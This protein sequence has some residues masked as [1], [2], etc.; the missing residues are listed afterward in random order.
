MTSSDIAKNL[1]LWLGTALPAKP[2]P[3]DT[4]PG[5]I[6]FV[7]TFDSIIRSDSNETNMEAVGVGL[8]ALALFVQ[9]L[10]SYKLFSTARYLSSDLMLLKTKFQIEETRLSQWGL[11]WGFRASPLECRLAAAIEDTGHGVASIV[12]VTLLQ[13][14]TLLKE[15]EVVSTRHD[16]TNNHGQ[17]YRGLSWALR[18]KEKLESIVDNL[19]D[20]NNA[21]YEL[22]PKRDEA[23]LVEAVACAL[24][25]HSSGSELDNLITAVSRLRYA[26]ADKVA[27]FK[28]AYQ[29][30]SSEEEGQPSLSP[31]RFSTL[32][33]DASRFQFSNLYS[34]PARTFAELDNSRKV[35]VEWKGYHPGILSGNATARLTLRHRV[36]HFAV[37]MSHHSPRPEAFN[38][39]TCIGYF[40]QPSRERFGFAYDLPPNVIRCMP[41]TLQ[42]LFAQSMPALGTRFKMAVSLSKSL[43][44]LHTS[45]W[46][47]K[48][49]HSNNVVLFQAIGTKL[50]EFENPYLLGFGFSRPDGYGEE[51][52]HERSAVA[53]LNQLYRHPEVQCQTP[54]RYQASDDIYSLGLVLLEVALWKSLADIEGRRQTTREPTPLNMDK[55]KASVASLPKKVGIIYTAVVEKCL[56]TSQTMP[57]SIQNQ[58][59]AEWNAERLRERNLFYW[60]VVKRL[61]ECRA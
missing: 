45:G 23:S 15:Y 39:L 27:R 42:E 32:E 1:G 34:S 30:L 22:M 8:S 55:I 5:P 51:T 44:L 17:A 60:D 37:L 13:I 41:F 47:H 2:V 21:L 4:K 14:S 49:I 26:D 29:M 53:S 24:T 28:R 54:R 11:H 12:Q 43:N 10:K 7:P 19:N 48:S 20:F 18:D 57:T 3:E 46:L 35:I 33:L 61:E 16:D 6:P 38:T 50:P 31:A 9:C 40:D 52:F 58:S 36:D 25:R 56:S 59:A